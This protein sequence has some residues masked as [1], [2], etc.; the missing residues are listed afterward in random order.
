MSRTYTPGL[1]I[2]TGTTLQKVRQLPLK[3]DVHC[4]EGDIVKPDTVV[5]STKIPGNVHMVNISNLLNIEP[6]MVPECMLVNVDEKIEK[7]QIIAESKG[8]FGLF[9][10]VCEGNSTRYEVAK[11]L[12]K[13]LNLSN[14]IK[15]HSVD[16]SFFEKTYFAK[17]PRSEM[18]INKKK[19]FQGNNSIL[20]HV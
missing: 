14:N 8:I 15:M 11:E 19:L 16:S 18:L 5:A 4:K 17:R 20:K 3:G 2:L 9:N 12:L 10:L 13:I 1:K 6:E 7:D